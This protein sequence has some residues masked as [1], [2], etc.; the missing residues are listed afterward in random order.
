MKR[1]LGQTD[2]EITPIGLG[3][4]QFAGGAGI[5]GMMFPEISQETMNGIIR[6]ALDGGIAW[7]DT[8]THE[9]L[10]Q[11]SNFIHAIEERQ[12]LKVACVEEIA[13]RV[14]LISADDVY[15]IAKSMEKSGYGQYL[16]GMLREIA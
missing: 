13:F 9:A 15:R 16:L 5:F 10:L 3:V 14:G 8:G 4:M 7:F 11:A 1:R 12:G 2:I 6:T